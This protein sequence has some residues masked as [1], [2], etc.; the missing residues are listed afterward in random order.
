MKTW[1]LVAIVVIFIAILAFSCTSDQ[2]SLPD[3]SGENSIELR[4]PGDVTVETI[5]NWNSGNANTECAQAGSD[6]AFSIKVD[7]IDGIYTVGSSPEVSIDVDVSDDGLELIWNSDYKVC[8][9][10]VKG[11]PSAN[12]YTIEGG[13]CT[14]DGNPFLA[15]INPNNGNTYG[16]S[17]ITFCVSPDPCDSEQ[18]TCYE[19]ETAWADGDRYTNRGNWATYTAYPGDGGVVDIY[20][21]KNKNA[22]TVTFLDN[23]DGTIDLNIS[24]DNDFVFYYDLSDPVADDNVKVQD[25]TSAPSGNPA[26]GQFDHKESAAFGSSSYTITVPLNNYYGI[27]LDVA[28]VEDCEY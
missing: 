22:G 25:Y 17:H 26:P 4:D 18:E 23:L 16:I 19:E 7:P 14:N 5:L 27:H 6:C 3:D 15:P 21:G 24:L 10:V 13:S 1:N 9:I 28:K 8:A 11:G 12:I 20:A 2:L